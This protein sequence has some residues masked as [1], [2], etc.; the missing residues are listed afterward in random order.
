MSDSRS[1]FAFTAAVFI[2]IL[3]ELCPLHVATRLLYCPPKTGSNWSWRTTFLIGW[4]GSQVHRTHS[5][6]HHLCFSV[7]E[8]L[9][10]SS[11]VAGWGDCSGLGS[12]EIRISSLWYWEWVWTWNKRGMAVARSWCWQIGV[13]WDYSVLTLP[14]YA[15]QITWL[16][17]AGRAISV[18]LA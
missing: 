11:R 2:V 4:T 9:P 13:V 15:L 14:V 6:Y 1:N 12:S 8:N 3:A 7:H 18:F 16:A 10:V 5:L 17:L